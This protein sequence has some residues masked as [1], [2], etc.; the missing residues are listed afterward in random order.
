[1][2]IS[3]RVL[4]HVLD[5]DRE[6]GVCPGNRLH[7]YYLT[8]LYATNRVIACSLIC[9]RNLDCGKGTRLYCCDVISVAGKFGM[10]IITLGKLSFLMSCW[11][12]PTNVAPI[13]HERCA[14]SGATCALAVPHLSSGVGSEATW[15]RLLVAFWC[16]DT[17]H[18][19]SPDH[20]SD[21]VWFAFV[22]S[23]GRASSRLGCGSYPRL[24]SLP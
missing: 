11:L 8:R 7:L 23:L 6:A 18:M 17:C 10:V 2:Q 1:V 4:M 3:G 14:G 12:A 22:S 24:D 15:A 19:V 21:R 13:Q 5:Q 16:K 20:R 9:N